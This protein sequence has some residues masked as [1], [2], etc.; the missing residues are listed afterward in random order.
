MTHIKFT[1]IAMSDQNKGFLGGVTDSKLILSPDMNN[2]VDM[3]QPSE[4]ES[5][6]S[7]IL[8]AMQV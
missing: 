7:R 4:R 6:G 1:T 2:T 8:Q 5:Q 3:I